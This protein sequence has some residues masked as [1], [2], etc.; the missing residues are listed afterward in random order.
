MP[1]GR[2]EIDMNVFWAVKDC[3]R[4]ALQATL[5]S[6]PEASMQAVQALTSECVV[7]HGDCSLWGVMLPLLLDTAV[8]LQTLALFGQAVS[9][10]G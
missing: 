7:R 1:A 8:A 2:T 5:P 4:A 10:Q 6:L 9:R 3:L